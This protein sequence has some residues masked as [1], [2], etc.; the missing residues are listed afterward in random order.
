MLVVGDPDQSIYRFRG[1]DIQNILDFQKD[2][3]D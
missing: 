2:Y 3:P 1:A